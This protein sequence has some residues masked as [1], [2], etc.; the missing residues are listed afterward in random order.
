MCIFSRSIVSVTDTLIFARLSGNGQQYLAYQMKYESEEP[1]AMILPL[2]V[3][4]PSAE[5]SVEFIDLSEYE[6]FFDRLGRAFPSIRSLTFKT[7]IVA[8]NSLSKDKLAVHEVGNFV[9]SFVPTVDDFDRLDEQF[10]IPKETW[11][12][13]P[14]YANYGFAVFQ[15][16]D[17]VGKPHPMAFRFKT[18]SNNLFFPTVHIHDGEVHTEEDF[19]H[20]LF[21]QHA[22]FDSVVGKYQGPWEVD[23]ATGVV[24]SK[25]IAGKYCNIEKAKGLIAPDLLLHRTRLEGRLPNQDTL[26]AAKGS[27]AVPGFNYR[28]LMAW[29][30]LAIPVAATAWFFNR[31]NKIQAARNESESGSDDKSQQPV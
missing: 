31:R 16:K 7:A 4:L 23:F 1:N 5:S 29:W 6:D 24:R 11:A 15:L 10:V 17:L 9:A 12:K 25:D 22:G 13:I 20:V 21:M 2:P 28:Q 27:P 30:P 14:E 3:E 19:D 26:L 18:R 8:S